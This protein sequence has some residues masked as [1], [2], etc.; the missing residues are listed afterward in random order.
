MHEPVGS[1]GHLVLFWLFGIGVYS[2]RVRLAYVFIAAWCCSILG[3]GSSGPRKYPVTG[4]VTVNGKPASLVRV[5]FLH[6]DQ[7]LPGNLKYPVGMT[8][9]AGVFHLSTTGDKDGAVEGEY[10]VTFEWMSANELEAFDQLGGK[11]A[12]PKTTTFR[13]KVEAKSNRLPPFE[14]VVPETAIVSKPSRG[15]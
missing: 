15:Q 5:Q 4:T 8:D 2:M 6:A 7:S 9:E 11:F 14:I 13:A 1:V 10:T 3:C 12:D